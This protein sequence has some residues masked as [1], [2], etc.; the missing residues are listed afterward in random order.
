MLADMLNLFVSN[1]EWARL[2]GDSLAALRADSGS[3]GEGEG[4]RPWR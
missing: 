3:E 4:P 1:S 2:K